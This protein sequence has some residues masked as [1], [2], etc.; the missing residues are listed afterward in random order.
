M[1]TLLF[2]RASNA[3]RY[4][5]RSFTI[6]NQKVKINIE[7]V[8][9]DVID[10]LDDM[11]ETGSPTHNDVEEVSLENPEA[12]EVLNDF[13]NNNINNSNDFVPTNDEFFND[14]FLNN[15]ENHNQICNKNNEKS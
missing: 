13:N 6:V 8:P 3:L 4:F 2:L 10:N 14:V 15:N 12:N 5:S 1:E 9:K 7:D 11:L